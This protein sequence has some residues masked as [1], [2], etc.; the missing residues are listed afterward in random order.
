MKIKEVA[1]F[2]EGIAPLDLQE[3]Y[4]NAGLIVG[5]AE[6][7]CT[8]ILVSLDVT[9]EI[10]K[11]AISKKCNLIVGH[12]PIIFRGL[13]KLNGKNYVE[14][15]VMMA[16]KN[17]IAIYAIHTN[18]DN[19]L[20]GVNNKIAKKLNLQNCKVLLPKEGTLEKLV[21]FAPV[22][23]AEEVRNALFE[24]GAGAIGNY[25][26]CSFNVEGAGT[27]RAL[28][29]SHPYVGEEGKQHEENEVRIEVIFPSHLE[30]KITNALKK[31]HPY[32][33][34]AFYIQSLRNTRENI[35]SGLVG[36]LPAAVTET[37]LMEMLK[38]EFH[39]KVIRHTEFLNQPVKKIAV[40]GGA[41]FFLLPAAIAAGAQVFIT[42]D[43][44][45]HEFFD[46]EKRILLA[47]IGHYESEQFTVE[48]LTEFLQ[49]KFSNFAVQKTE[50]NTNPVRY[51]C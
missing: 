2:L 8:G 23:N 5:D 19:I 18:L 45:Y 12:H 1:Q 15:T 40:C 9:E 6:S 30:H 48:L 10:V 50:I 37:E 44:K 39:L 4:D 47:D 14:R 41:G 13:K 38:S 17:E 16:I 24:A 21:T 7:E 42:A 51:F 22:K 32:E 25:N 3:S 34:V 49:K 46:A 29:G 28:E 35:G 27:F 31:S 26:E 36:E 11:E 33:E 43:I 20:E